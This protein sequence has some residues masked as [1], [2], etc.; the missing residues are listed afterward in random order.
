MVTKRALVPGF[1][2]PVTAQRVRQNGWRRHRHRGQ[3]QDR[4][5]TGGTSEMQMGGIREHFLAE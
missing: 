4:G 1:T 2:G 5:S 3:G